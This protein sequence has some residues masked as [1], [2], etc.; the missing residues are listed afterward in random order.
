MDI[1]KTAFI[2]D[3]H[4]FFDPMIKALQDAGAVDDNLDLVDGWRL[5]HLGDFVDRGPNSPRVFATARRWQEEHGT[6]RVIRLF[7]NHELMY[8]DGCGW[9][10]EP[11]VVP[12]TPFMIEDGTAGKMQFAY[13]FHGNDGEEWLCV[14]AGLQAGWEEYHNMPIDDAVDKINSIGREFLKYPCEPG[15]SRDFMI[16]N[17]VTRSRGGFNPNAGVT[18]CDYDYDLR[19][20]EAKLV[21]KQIVG[22]TIQERGINL[23]PHGKIW[24]INV[25]YY[26][27]QVLVYDHETGK[28]NKTKRFV[29]Q[30]RQQWGRY[31]EQKKIA[32]NEGAEYVGDPI[33]VDDAGFFT[34]AKKG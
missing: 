33:N 4:G 31:G 21:H 14:H 29:G 8:V 16:I 13:A 20:N 2:S 34:R 27:A 7:G 24:A 30:M 15:M 11:A 12:L 22:H 28:F 19:P 10:D 9:F 17:G 5:V 1:T 25:P 6:D 18:W 32:N 23:A 26:H 3:S